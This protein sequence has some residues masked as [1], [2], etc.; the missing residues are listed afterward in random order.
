M[1]FNRGGIFLL[2]ASLG[3][4]FSSLLVIQE[5]VDI[6][7]SCVGLDNGGSTISCEEVTAHDPLKSIGFS[8][9][10]AGLAYFI[11]IFVVTLFRH[12]LT[13]FKKRFINA[14]KMFI[15]A[16]TLYMVILTF[17]HLTFLDKICV[18]CLAIF[19]TTILLSI[20]EFYFSS[21][22]NLGKIKASHA[23]LPLLILISPLL[24]LFM[25]LG[26]DLEKECTFE[27][28]LLPQH[29]SLYEKSVESGIKKGNPDAQITVL[30]YFD[31]LCGHCQRVYPKLKSLNENYGEDVLFVYVPFLLRDSH[32]PL[33]NSLYLAAD[34]GKFFKLLDKMFL[35]DEAQKGLNSQLL[36]RFLKQLDL[37]SNEDI[38]RITQGYYNEQIKEDTRTAVDMGIRSTPT[39]LINGKKLE[40]YDTIDKCLENI[41]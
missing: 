24:L 36:M 17:Y 34:N 5:F 26:P 33:H 37:A 22:P 7:G 31:P 16:G 21:Y 15:H 28:D 39:F 40:R 38:Q 12:N 35:S 23:S 9:S 10:I 30:E 25:D 8:S 29:Q 18:Y 14:E 1:K 11:V 13:Y 41:L 3:A 20:S 27:E 32:L 6:S 4:F 2:L 19:L